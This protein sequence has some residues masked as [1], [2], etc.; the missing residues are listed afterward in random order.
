MY[1]KNLTYYWLFP[2]QRHVAYAHELMFDHWI[3]GVFIGLLCVF[4]TYVNING[5]IGCI[6]HLDVLSE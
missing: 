6:F 2:P 5:Q 4:F 1:L 3:A